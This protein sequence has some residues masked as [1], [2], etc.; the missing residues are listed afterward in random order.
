M[1]RTGAC[2]RL[3]RE[4]VS[5]WQKLERILLKLETD[6]RRL[7]PAA[8][9]L[10]STFQILQPPRQFG[11]LDTHPTSER[12]AL[13]AKTSRAAFAVLMSW[14]TFLLL[15]LEP[16]FQTQTPA[17]VATLASC[18]VEIDY[19]TQLQHSELWAHNHR[20]RVGVIID[21]RCNFQHLLVPLMKAGIPLWIFW[22]KKS[23]NEHKN[24]T[25]SHLR[26]TEQELLNSRSAARKDPG[27]SA[28]SEW[29][30]PESSAISVWGPS[31]S[32]GWGQ[33]ESSAS[34]W[35]PSGSWGQPESSATS[36]LGPSG[37]SG[38]GESR[39]S[40]LSEWGASRSSEWGTPTETSPS[41]GWAQSGTAASSGS[42]GW[43][44][45]K[46][47]TSSGWGVSGTSGW[48]TL[49]PTS[50]PRWHGLDGPS[51][52][53]LPPVAVAKVGEHQLPGEDWKQF[54]ARRSE[55]RKKRIAAEDPKRRHSR[56]QKEAQ[57]ANKPYPGR[58]GPRV[59]LWVRDDDTGTWFRESKTRGEIQSDWSSYSRKCKVYDYYLNQWDIIEGLADSPDHP[60]SDDDDDDDDNDDYHFFKGL[61]STGGKAVGAGPGED[62]ALD[63][64]DSAGNAAVSK[65]AETIIFSPA[66]T[67]PTDVILDLSD[68]TS[69]GYRSISSTSD[70][71]L[72]T[73]R[74]TSSTSD[75]ASET[76]SELTSSSSVSVS[77][78]VSSPI[79]PP[80][81][82]AAR[83]AS[84]N[85]G[86]SSSKSLAQL[87][88]S[89]SIFTDED[90]RSYTHFIW[91]APDFTDWMYER[92]GYQ[93]PA[94]PLPTLPQAMHVP[95]EVATNALGYPLSEVPV[96]FREQ[97]VLFFNHITKNSS[98]LPE[99]CW[100]LNGS[101]DSV[102][103]SSPPHFKIG[104]LQSVASKTQYYVIQPR[105][106]TT[107]TTPIP[108]WV[109]LLDD[110]VTVVQICRLYRDSTVYDI[111]RHLFNHGI[112]FS[113]CIP[114]SELPVILPLRMP[115]TLGWRPANHIIK[116]SEYPFYHDKLYYFF[117]EPHSRAAFGM[118]G[119]VW[120]LACAVV[121]RDFV[122]NT[123]LGGPSDEVATHRSTFSFTSGERLCDDNL[124]EQELDFICGVYKV[125]T[126]KHHIS[127]VLHFDLIAA[128]R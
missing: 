26:P 21:D 73:S 13:A 79:N 124:T 93:H 118:G 53:S 103:P 27:T 97:F 111:L 42:S 126:G 69:I 105:Q 71:V 29:G 62:M 56:L 9:A 87:T 94:D 66:P 83:N 49:A 48:T 81:D 20:E 7:S 16:S 25:F 96:K 88:S 10:P 108:E 24:Q 125:S 128:F 112:S 91:K 11:Y 86:D 74:F 54:L 82:T 100:D 39:N 18:G 5:S 1:E 47:S 120:R 92:W 75:L 3:N 63:V 119:I 122:D 15:Q 52:T 114:E 8:H 68:S 31:G 37:S 98:I 59:F 95:L 85:L 30:Q 35:G 101:F 115:Q 61:V 32:S 84:V 104:L 44:Q 121:D 33:S 106:P 76:L 117:R 123:V 23:I 107:P 89:T 67:I 57:L 110:P 55:I 58:S 116:P 2:W 4:T 77:S 22:G 41:S 6:L 46:A 78:I 17:W 127:C 40:P 90:Y 102:L 60:W 113:T 34:V 19:I 50:S 72:P 65:P 43:G 12:L 99:D 70:L 64:R 28:P 109:L 45:H 38:W 80:P 51:D 36:V 14:L